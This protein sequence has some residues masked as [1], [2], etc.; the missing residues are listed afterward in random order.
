MNF[1]A[2][3]KM[4]DWIPYKKNLQVLG[5]ISQC[6]VKVEVRYLAEDVNIMLNLS[7]V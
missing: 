4:G 2:E 3:K 6:L 5:S 1:D 7:E